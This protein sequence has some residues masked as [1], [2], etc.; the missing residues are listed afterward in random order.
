MP[1]R[2]DLGHKLNFYTYIEEVGEKICSGMGVSSTLVTL[3]KSLIQPYFG[4]FC[5]PLLGTCD[6]TLRNKLQVTIQLIQIRLTSTIV[7]WQMCN[8]DEHKK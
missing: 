3:Y 1:R 5:S 8:M 2:G 4:Y 6:K 7:K